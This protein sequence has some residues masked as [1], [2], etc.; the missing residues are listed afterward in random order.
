ML[1]V[2]S[3]PRPLTCPLRVRRVQSSMDVL[4]LAE[5]YR[6]HELRM[7]VAG[8]AASAVEGAEAS[9]PAGASSGPP[10]LKRALSMGHV[11]SYKCA[12][13]L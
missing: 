10:Q 12:G 7:G 3:E 5:Q 4:A 9:P 8:A 13:L 2:M 6:L 1:G 11:P